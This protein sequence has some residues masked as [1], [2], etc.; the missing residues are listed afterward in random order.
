MSTKRKKLYSKGD[1]KLAQEE[2][3]EQ[4]RYFTR[5]TN[6]RRTHQVRIDEK[7]HKR[8]KEVGSSEKVMLSFLLDAICEFY[9][10]H[11]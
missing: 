11:N 10:K 4:N 9:F 8:L 5:K 1:I 7:W 6:K 3:K 2:Q